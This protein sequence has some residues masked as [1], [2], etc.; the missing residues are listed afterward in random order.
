VSHITPPPENCQNAK[1]NTP[2]KPYLATPQ[3]PKGSRGIAVV[4]H[5]RPTE[6][7]A[8]VEARLGRSAFRVIGLAK[9]SGNRP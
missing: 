8:K 2:S 3:C 7:S 4:V 5:F 6:K 1:E 9:A